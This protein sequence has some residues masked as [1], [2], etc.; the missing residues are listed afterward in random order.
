MTVF[1][2]DLASQS[3]K[4]RGNDVGRTLQKSSC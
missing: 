1:Q 3:W 4:E 2:Q